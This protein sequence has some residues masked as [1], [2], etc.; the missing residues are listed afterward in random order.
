MVLLSSLMVKGL[1]SLSLAVLPLYFRNS[2]F[3]RQKWWHRI[4]YH[5]LTQWEVWSILGGPLFLPLQV[6]CCGKG[7]GAISR[8]LLSHS[9]LPQWC[10]ASL[11]S[12]WWGAGMVW[13][14]DVWWNWAKSSMRKWQAWISSNDLCKTRRQ[15]RGSQPLNE[16]TASWN[17]SS[18]CCGAVALV[19][20]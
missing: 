17:S 15:M 7:Q 3:K 14:S 1:H 5:A 9:G 20:T 10:T 13:G 16:G 19:L 12:A 4:L 18:G 11:Q 6:Q 2:F 8:F